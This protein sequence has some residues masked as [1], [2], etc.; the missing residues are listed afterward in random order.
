MRYLVPESFDLQKQQEKPK[1]QTIMVMPLR[2]VYIFGEDEIRRA[3]ELEYAYKTERYKN[4][5]KIN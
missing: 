1:E 2:V 5:K 4:G 3:R